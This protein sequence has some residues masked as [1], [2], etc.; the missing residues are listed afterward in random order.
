[1]GNVHTSP[2]RWEE[3]MSTVV[4]SRLSILECPQLVQRHLHSESHVRMTTR[5]ILRFLVLNTLLAK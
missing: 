1:M 2:N 3:Q 5:L 4:Q